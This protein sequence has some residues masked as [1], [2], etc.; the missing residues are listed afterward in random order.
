MKAIEF[1]AKQVRL[2]LVLLWVFTGLAVLKFVPAANT[3]GRILWSGIATALIALFLFQ[4]KRF[5]PLFRLIMIGSGYI[6]NFIFLVI[7]TAVFFLILTPLSLI[8][9][10]FGKRFLAIRLEP[11]Q[12]SYYEQ[13]ENPTGYEHQF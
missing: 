9:R 11:R 1:K 13:P 3:Q 7:S 12:N 8:M 10:L 4:P 6:G 2:F 5:F